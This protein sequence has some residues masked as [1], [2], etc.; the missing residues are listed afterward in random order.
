MPSNSSRAGLKWAMRCPRIGHE[1]ASHRKKLHLSKNIEN[2][3][4]F[5]K[6]E[7]MN[8]KRTY[9]SFMQTDNDF[10]CV[11]W[12]NIFVIFVLIC[13]RLVN[14]LYRLIAIKNFNRLKFNRLT[15]L[16]QWTVNNITNKLL[17][18]MIAFFKQNNYDNLNIWPLL[19]IAH[20]NRNND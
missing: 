16:F 13:N 19:L 7:S 3:V 5:N 15:S 1:L 8:Y 6:Y 10:S 14:R 20:D 9:H 4:N 2:W 18:L 17:S 12:L 11:Y